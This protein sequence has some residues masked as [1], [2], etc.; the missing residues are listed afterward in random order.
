M[1][2]PMVAGILYMPAKSK[3]LPC[4]GG[5]GFCGLYPASMYTLHLSWY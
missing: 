2:Y 1:A 3:A 5:I 4:E